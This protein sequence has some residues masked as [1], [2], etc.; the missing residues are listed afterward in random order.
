MRVKVG[1]AGIDFAMLW[2]NLMRTVMSV[3]RD[4]SFP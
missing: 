1:T 2:G 3:E 4:D